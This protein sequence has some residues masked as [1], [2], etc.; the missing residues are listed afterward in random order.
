MKKLPIRWSFKKGDRILYKTPKG[1]VKT[2]IFGKQK[3]Y[4]K[5]LPNRTFR[6]FRGKLEFRQPTISEIFSRTMKKYGTKIA[7]NFY[8]PN[9][10]LELLNSRCSIR[11]IDC[12]PTISEPIKFS[13]R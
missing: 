9:P 4:G 5:T 2:F 7:E 13:T 6:Y 3:W 1:N 8:A 10:F 12:G 11:A